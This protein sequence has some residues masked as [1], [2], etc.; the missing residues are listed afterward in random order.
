M[1]LAARNI[2]GHCFIENNIRVD[3]IV[4]TLRQI[5]KDK[6]FLPKVQVIDSD[7]ESLFKNEAYYEFLNQHNISASRSS[8][9]AHQNKVIERSFRTLKDIIKNKLKIDL[10]SKEYLL[11]ILRILVK[12]LT[13]SNTL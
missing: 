3:H 13:L 6:D 1:D 5:L 11:I 4:E 7:K 9:K 10:K 8:A 2:V 12:R